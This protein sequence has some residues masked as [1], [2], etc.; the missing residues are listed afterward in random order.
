[1]KQFLKL[2]KTAKLPWWRCILYIVMSVVVSSV[3]AG[4]PQVA[5]DIMEGN[6]FDKSLIRT[7]VVVTIV[8]GVIGI[9]L[10]LFQGWITNITDRNL[11]RTI[12]RKLI[13]LPMKRYQE[14][15]PSSLISRVTVD[16]SQ[17]SYLIF[18]LIQMF[19]MIYTLVFAL[20][21]VWNMSHNICFFLMIVI[22]WGIGICVI[23]GRIVSKANDQRQNAYSKLT[24][25]V[26][27]RLF[28]IKLIKSHGTEEKEIADCQKQTEFLFQKD[29]AVAKLQIILQP[30]EYSVSAFC[31][32]ILLVYGGYLATKN[33]IGADDLVTL[34]LYME[35][36]P[37]YIIQPI[38]CYETIKEVQGM[39]TEASRLVSLPD[40]EMQSK[41]SFALADADISFQ[42][43]TFRYGEETILSH[44]NLV[45]PKGKFTAI[46][47]PSGA[48]KTTVLKLLERFYE[49]DEGQI[50]FGEC[51][52]E[53][54]HRDEWR[55]AFGFLQQNS[56]LLSCSIRE[57]ITFGVDDFISDE[58][59]EAVTKK[60]NAF[61]FIK[62]LPEGFDTN[63]GEIGGKL[64][65]GERQ[66]IALARTLMKNPDFLL[67]DEATSSLDAK[68][69]SV[70]WRSLQEA[71]QGKTSVVV[72]H[73]MKEIKNADHIVVMNRGTVV[74]EGTHDELYGKNDIYTTFCDLQSRVNDRRNKRN[75]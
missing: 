2:L 29:K 15:S 42:D 54:I 62:Q 10:A 53:D 6:I 43:V 46:V 55:E 1:M 11:Q 27:E 7:Y 17:V 28:N 35:I 45:I 73:S 44:L 37:V 52:V 72:S 59:L 4:L 33:L 64:S 58:E 47:G 12:G 63:V 74:G 66:R 5:G 25:Y 49:P 13:H 26:A 38:M 40:E 48:G 18:Y 51:P 61:D 3:T 68:N 56:P 36:I 71:M 32:L 16:T 9:L 50:C 30:L 21:V 60:T 20:V 65:G 70:V 69:A 19:A 34:V 67:L 22:P 8:S 24:N 31:K 14:M 41:K 57:N 39:T 75:G 23:T